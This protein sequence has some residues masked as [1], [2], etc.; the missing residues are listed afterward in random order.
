M[1]AAVGAPS[2]CIVP[3]TGV[4][5]MTYRDRAGHLFE[6]WH[7]PENE[8]GTTDLTENAD[9]P[10]TVGNPFAYV[11]RG[12]STVICLF[13]SNEGTVRS[14]YWQTGPVGHDDLGGTA[15]APPAAGDPVGY[16]D[17]AAD[18][19]HVVYRGHDSHLH[20]LFWVGIA[21]VNYGGN[22]TGAIGA[23][24]A[25]GDPAAFCNA[26]GV[27]IVPYRSVDGR[28]LSVYW[29][30]G[31]S[32]LDDLSG[33]AGTP[34]PIGDPV[35]FY[36]P[37]DDTH[38]VFYQA[39]DNH[40]WQLAW[41]GVAPVI[42]RNITGGVGAPLPAGRPAAYDSPIT[43]T[44]HV[45]YHTADGRIQTLWWHPGQ[46]VQHFEFLRSTADGLL[47]ADRPTAWVEDPPP[48]SPRPIQRLAYRARNGSI[49]TRSF[50]ID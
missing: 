13:R 9:A 41:Q 45:W 40:L 14:L 35:A 38:H 50:G 17:A 18:A 48:G 12:R 39:D 27:Q 22:L 8:T 49:A 20:E 37:N 7:T 1:T 16:H 42:G 26:A 19:H 47:A 5:V 31:P 21:P 34:P 25:A 23:P 11:D 30:Q 46:P 29:S 24:A 33:V 4:E 2:A 32:G 15:H 43:R 10:P 3:A 28:I 44:R 36:S 6:Q